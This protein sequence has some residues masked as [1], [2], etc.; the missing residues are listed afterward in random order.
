MF[1]WAAIDFT[2]LMKGFWEN[3][4]ALTCRRVKTNRRR[5]VSMDIAKKTEHRF[6]REIQGSPF[7]LEPL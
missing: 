5:S 7:F 6:F 1:F 3:D 4:A 2:G